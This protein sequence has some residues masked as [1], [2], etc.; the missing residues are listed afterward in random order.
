MKVTPE[1]IRRFFDDKAAR[2]QDGK[3]KSDLAKVLGVRPGAISEILGGMRRIE[4]EE[5]LKILAY[6]SGSSVGASP[7]LERSENR[8]SDHID[9]MDVAFGLD[10]DS[11]HADFAKPPFSGAI[12]Q[13]S[14]RMG[15]GSTGD[16]IT[17][18]AGEMRTIEPVAAWWGIPEPVLRGIGARS[19]HLAAWPMDGDSMEPT[20]L[21]TD[22]VF[23][24]TRRQR[25]EPD[26]IWAVD[27]GQGRTLKR[28]TVR[29]HDGESRLILSSDNP[30]Y[31]EM[32]FGPDEVHIFGRYLFRFTVF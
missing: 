13:V 19:S 12:A 17:L 5:A 3:S 16:V 24:D 1:L 6:M 25:L 28:I 30:K 4:H 7:T 31:G 9:S 32:Q 18:T 8:A 14:G 10:R 21:R 26:G 22:V 11:D 23:I 20:I 29:K 27:Y 15:G 2:K